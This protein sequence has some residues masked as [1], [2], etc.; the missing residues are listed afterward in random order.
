MR[1]SDWSSDVCSSDLHPHG[2][3][4][5]RGIKHG[6]D[7]PQ[8]GNIN[9][10]AQAREQGSAAFHL[11]ACGKPH[12]HPGNAIESPLDIKVA[13]APGCRMAESGNLQCF[14]AQE[15]MDLMRDAPL[16]EQARAQEGDIP[17]DQACET[18][19]NGKASWRER[20]GPD[21]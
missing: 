20:G 7:D 19:Q 16:A 3:I 4:P 1:I 14:P 12:G 10:D 13:R 8:V 5:R 17:A 11:A 6:P 18:D 9:A 15:T 2:C 21:G